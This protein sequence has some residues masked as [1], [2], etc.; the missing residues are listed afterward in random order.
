MRI[1]QINASRRGHTVNG[2]MFCIKNYIWRFE[3][4]NL[5][6]KYYFFSNDSFYFVSTK[7]VE[8]VKSF[9]RL[10]W[11]MRREKLS[12]IKKILMTDVLKKIYIN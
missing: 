8:L 7:P 2:D 9:N 12:D 6:N 11:K 1:I 10:I 5:E 3:V 4:G